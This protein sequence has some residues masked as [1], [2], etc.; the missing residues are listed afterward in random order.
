M[1][2]GPNPATMEQ[3]NYVGDHVSFI[4]V[5]M[6]GTVLVW[7]LL[8]LGVLW[9]TKRAKRLDAEAMGRSA[10]SR[11][12]A[13]FNWDMFASIMNLVGQL[14]GLYQ[15]FEG[16]GKCVFEPMLASSPVG[17]G[18]R[19]EP[20]M[21]RLGECL[22][23]KVP[24]VILHLVF[25]L[26]GLAWFVS[27]LSS[28]D[29][30]ID[31]V[32]SED[33]VVSIVRT[34]RGSLLNDTSAAGPRQLVENTGWPGKSA[35]L[36]NRNRNTHSIRIHL[37]ADRAR[38]FAAAHGI[39]IHAHGRSSAKVEG[40]SD[41]GRVTTS[42][43]DDGQNLTARS[44][45]HVLLPTQ[46]R[47]VEIRTGRREKK[48]IHTWHGYA[49]A[50]A[51]Q[52]PTDSILPTTANYEHQGYWNQGSKTTLDELFAFHPLTEVSEVAEDELSQTLL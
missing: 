8:F 49:T 48:N 43:A 24:N 28:D 15:N 27:V 17:T 37:A 45:E 32:E 42:A 34:S 11:W 2:A 33:E 40:G 52:F 9:V 29:L 10:F 23:P 26:A 4:L 44:N 41:D 25:T 46:Q 38:R 13:G 22:V 21:G 35:S 50:A 20:G 12:V 6:L 19:K 14:V 30:Q 39:R 47:T 31:V 3:R 16:V 5:G 18:S 7:T 36:S 51:E 1:M